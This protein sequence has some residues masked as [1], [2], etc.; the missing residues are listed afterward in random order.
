[1]PW[2]KGP[3]YLGL[4]ANTFFTRVLYN[5]RVCCPKPLLVL[6]IYVFCHFFLCQYLPARDVCCCSLAIR[7]DTDMSGLA[8][9]YLPQDLFLTHIDQSIFQIN[10]NINIL[11]NPSFAKWSLLSGNIVN[12][13]ITSSFLLL[14]PPVSSLLICLQ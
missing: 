14:A 4:K 3:T 11:F 13:F 8:E 12:V 2:R 10:F 9:S 1:M 7:S 6:R 5:V